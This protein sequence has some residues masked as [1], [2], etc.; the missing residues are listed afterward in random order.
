MTAARF[1]TST[2]GLA[3]HLATGQD[4]QVRTARRFDL[5]A[6]LLAG[7]FPWLAFLIFRCGWAMTTTL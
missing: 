5:R 3:S 7:R 1:P 2:G 6:L 4:V